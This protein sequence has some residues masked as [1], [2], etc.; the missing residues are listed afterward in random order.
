M[1]LKSVQSFVLGFAAVALMAGLIMTPV[2]ASAEAKG[3]KKEQPKKE[4]D[5]QP[6]ADPWQVRCGDVS[7]G[8]AVVGKYCEMVQQIFVTQK[9]AD[10]ST[11]Q[12]LVEVVI[13]YPPTEKN[14][15]S[16][17]VILPLGILL[18]EE[19]T[20]EVDGSKLLDFNVRYCDNGG[21]A[22]MLQLSDKDI[23]KLSKGNEMLVKGKAANGQEILITLSLQGFEKARQQILPQKDAKKK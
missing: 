2:Y 16:A 5:T 12:R 9:D 8:Q 11:A 20:I 1:T 6:P 21:C 14:K 17:V 23:S 22:A 15:A 10:P 18:E 19:N 13:G 4:A 3:A 7:D